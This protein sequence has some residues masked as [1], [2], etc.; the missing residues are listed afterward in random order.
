MTHLYSLCPDSTPSLKP[1][2]KQYTVCKAHVQSVLYLYRQCPHCALSLQPKSSQYPIL[3]PMPREYPNV[4]SQCLAFNHLYS[5]CSEC[6]PLL[7]H[8]LRQ[9]LI[10][11]RS[12]VK[13][14]IDFLCF[15]TL[16]PTICQYNI[17]RNY[18]MC[19][20]CNFDLIWP[21]FDLD[22]W[23]YMSNSILKSDLSGPTSY[24][25]SVANTMLVSRFNI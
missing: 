21:L 12:R 17:F 3:M 20:V 8:K 5:P 22:T 1:K 25:V 10:K 18:V 15:F 13:Y 19:M 2:P 9:N 23:V 7:Q 4:F 6:T 24:I 16:L 11:S 14:D